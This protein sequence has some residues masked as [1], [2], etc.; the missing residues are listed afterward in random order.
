MFGKRNR[1]RTTVTN[2]PTSDR[3]KNC[4]VKKRTLALTLFVAWVGAN[5]VY[6]TLTA[7]NFAVFANSLHTGADFHRRFLAISDANR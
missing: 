4:D 1:D 6:P 3:R 5:D 7:D 2:L